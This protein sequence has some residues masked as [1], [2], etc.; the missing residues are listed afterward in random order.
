MALIFRKRAIC[1]QLQR[2]DL[3]VEI[4]SPKII[5]S[6]VG[7]AHKKASNLSKIVGN[8][9]LPLGM[10]MLHMGKHKL[11]TTPSLAFHPNFTSLKTEMRPGCQHTV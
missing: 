2:G 11:K 3:F 7:A 10:P 9:C 1:S 6:L 8:I 4:Q 5:P